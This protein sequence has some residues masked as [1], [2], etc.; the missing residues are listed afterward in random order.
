MSTNTRR[1]SRRAAAKGVTNA[2]VDDNVIASHSEV[3]LA[4]SLLFVDQ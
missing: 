2:S 4:Q 1:S 3:R